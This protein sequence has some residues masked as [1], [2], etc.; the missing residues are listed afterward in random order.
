M[1]RVFSAAAFLWVFAFTHAATVIPYTLKELAEESDAILV[2]KCLAT[3][4]YFV[5]LTAERERIYTNFMMQVKETVKGEPQGSV[6]ITERG[7]MVG[8]T[9]QWI[10]GVPAYATDEE[11]VVFLQ[12]SGDGFTTKGWAQGRYK[13]ESEPDT[14]RPILRRDLS[15]LHFVDRKR[16]A[17]RLK[18]IEANPENPPRTHLELT[19][20]PKDPPVIYLDDFL[21][22][23]KKHVGDSGKRRRP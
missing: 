5:T 23:V 6:I 18:E 10:P 21:A 8:A 2:V 3:S 19:D 13:I 11:F 15:G 4:S 14:D 16:M 1:L 7:G 20:R 22:E 9:L 12:K 17:Q